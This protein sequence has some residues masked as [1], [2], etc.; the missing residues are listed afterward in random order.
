MNKHTVH[1][2]RAILFLIILVMSVVALI[3]C[4]KD[5]KLHIVKYI[6]EVGGRIEGSSTQSIEFGSDCSPVTAIPEEGY[7]FSGWSDGI[8]T[9]ERHDCNVQT[10]LSLTAH[11]TRSPLTVMYSAEEGGRI[12]GI[13]S[14]SIAYGS[15]CY[16]VTAI[17]EE[18]YCFSGWSDGVL[19]PERHDRNVTANLSVTAKFTPI[20]FNA[21]YSTEI[22]GRIEG[23]STQTVIVGEDSS[24]VT[25]VPEEGY[26]FAGWSDGILGAE[27]TE[28][29]MQS[30]ISATASFVKKTKTFAY[31][32][33]GATSNNSQTEITLS[34]DSIGHA[35]FAI[36]EKEGYIF[37]GWYLDSEFKT[38]VTNENGFYYYGYGIFFS[39][40][41]TLYAKWSL[42][43]A[44]TYKILLV[45][46]DEI[47]TQL[48]TA[49]GQLVAV[50]YK[51]PLIERKICELIP[52]QYAKYLNE[53]FE[54][55]VVFEVDA[56]F[57]TSAVG[58]EV[59]TRG[60]SAWETRHYFIKANNIPEVGP[61]LKD[62]RSVTTAFCMNDYDTLLHMPGGL[63]GNKYAAVHLENMFRS[64]IINN[65]PLESYM[66]LSFV[67][68]TSSMDIY[69][70]EFTHTIEQGLDVFE[71]HSTISYYGNTIPSLET[72]R[73]Y[74]LNQ[75]VVDGV[76]VGI[77]NDY[78]IGNISISV[79]YAP[80]RIDSRH[81]GKVVK[82]P[83]SGD[84]LKDYVSTQIPYGSS[85]TVEAIP[86]E[87]YRF[88]H[89]S[90]GVKTAVRT[91]TNIISYMNVTAIF[92]KIS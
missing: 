89:W 51:M 25:A 32:Y 69:L 86:F 73:L 44:E 53:W 36:P 15:D 55:S 70:H 92:E 18:G 31:Q 6:A 2:R 60:I 79:G 23:E 88:S 43:D 75:A 41:D 28:K 72:T 39:A 42:P 84:Q 68:W 29:N 54:G 67:G 11:F 22:G 57:T 19:T 21:S 90:D 13:S 35:E 82:A 20:T 49:E 45:F 14:L 46:V 61:I 65:I 66:D 1:Y 63:G 52:V 47:H 12:K 48:K 5:V 37:N 10:N 81:L 59:F 91:D 50:D 4:T 64:M 71:Y 58:Q 9:A 87:G 26:L 33:N 76:T 80:N 3:G 30:D 77:P 40:S 38:K 24:P 85:I 8:M 17:P 27:R 16:P 78:W 62:Y 74:L 7:Y 83:D 34:Y 56:Y